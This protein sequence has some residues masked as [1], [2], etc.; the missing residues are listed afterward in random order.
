MKDLKE[1]ALRGGF[2]KMCA[3][4]ANF[5]LRIG[6]VMV[7]ARLLDP[8]DFGLVGM[9]TAFTGAFN[10]LKDAGLSVA[11][12]QR[13]EISDAQISNLFW[14]NMVVG[15]ALALVCLAIG[16]LLV[17]FYHEP[18]L[19]WV[20][21]TLGTGFA[22]NAA[23]VQHSALLQREMRF[24]ALA[25]IDVVSWAISITLSITLALLGFG[26]WALVCLTVSLPAVST[27]GFWLTSRWIPS[28]PRRGVGVGSMI[29]FGSTITVNTIVI[30]L[31]Y[32]TD[33]I[34]IGKLWGATALGIYGR[35]Y[36]L[37]NIP[38]DNLNGAVGEVAISA[39]SRVQG[40]G[41]RFKRYFLKS[42]SLVVALTLPLTIACWLY[43]AEIMDVMLGP[44]WHSAAPVFRLLAP[45]IVAFAMLNPLG[46]LLIAG[47]HAGRSLKMALCIAPVVVVGYLAG[48]PFG[49]TGVALGYSA[50][51]A[52]LVIPMIKWATAGSGISLRDVGR[53]AR[54]AAMSAAAAA[55][56]SYGSV[57]WLGD[58]PAVI[59]L[60]VGV[61]VLAAVYVAVLFYGMGQKDF[62]LTLL[63]D[64]KH[65]RAT[66]ASAVVAS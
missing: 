12:V 34:L 51:M 63:R 13:A 47:G 32:N 40:D 65:A 4:G 42:Y 52:V 10:L 14:V 19:F 33:K 43:A 38:T 61:G 62:Y 41:D 39:L 15:A 24:V 28:R 7:L 50:A 45:T 17:N 3:Q 37:S 58:S 60:A 55:L 49:I 2:A 8:N 25:T 5:S 29:R 26:Y 30:Y 31:A 64:S 57:L 6:S 54:P 44:K 36:Q 16:P 35:A 27:T 23:G 48:T 20:A 66:E 22:F 21:A 18:R 56:L 1:R 46:W 53:A 59:R 11:T 9:V